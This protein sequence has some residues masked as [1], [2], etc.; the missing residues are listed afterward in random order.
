MAHGATCTTDEQDRM[1]R[2][3]MQ[4]LI[5]PNRNFAMFTLKPIK[6]HLS[7]CAFIYIGILH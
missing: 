5:K 4:C 1:K 7:L 2:Y 6:P 3:K